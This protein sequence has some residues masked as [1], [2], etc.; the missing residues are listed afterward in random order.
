MSA[1]RYIAV[2]RNYEDNPTIVSQ[3]ET[4]TVRPYYYAYADRTL[5]EATDESIG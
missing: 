4:L 3:H 2:G 1:P 5:Y